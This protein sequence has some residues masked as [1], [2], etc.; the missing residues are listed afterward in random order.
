MK[1]KKLR[2]IDLFAGIGGFHNA[3]SEFEA[4]CVFASEWDKH[5]S[6]TY[7]ANYNIMPVG[8]ITQITEEN[9]PTHD[10]LCAGFPCQTF[11]ISGK[12]QGFT[13]TR[14]TLFYDIV[15]IAQYHKPK[16]LFLENVKN[17]IRHDSGK[18]LDT[19]IST[20]EKIGY[21]VFYKVLNA[22]HFG[23]P[24]NR[25]RIYIVCFR[26]DILSGNFHFPVP[27]NNK[28]ALQDFL[29]ENPNNVKIINREDI[30]FT[31]NFNIDINLLGE[32]NLPNRPIQIGIINK[33]GQGERIYHTLGHAI[34]LS[35]YGGGVGSK[36]GLYKVGNIIRK[37]STREC[38][39]IQGYSDEFKI[40]SS[41]AQAYKQ[42]GNT[43][44]V[45]VIKAILIEIEKTPISLE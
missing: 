44:A 27:N 1:L 45:N 33:G 5:A 14:G 23:L 22:S 9:I 17:L 18:T 6:Q 25:E 35:A 31:K 11:S 36:T 2:F 21:R 3:L 41:P 42:F 15:R 39:R 43:V 20:L 8:D 40:V 30:V 26:K 7:L 19:I 16:I 34:T 29:E 4:K 12:R 13:D 24:Q 38:A 10:I 37:L 28:V 32:T